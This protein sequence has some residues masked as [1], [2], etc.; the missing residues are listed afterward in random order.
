M[1]LW[2]GCGALVS[3]DV[4]GRDVEY[5]LLPQPYRGQFYSRVYIACLLREVDRRLFFSV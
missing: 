5:L 2:G 1:M 3:K 4:E